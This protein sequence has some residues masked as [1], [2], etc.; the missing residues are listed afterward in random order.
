M[1]TAI[2]EYGYFMY[3]LG[4]HTVEDIDKVKYDGRLVILDD[5]RQWEVDIP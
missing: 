3:R 2:A 1:K 5:G 4:K